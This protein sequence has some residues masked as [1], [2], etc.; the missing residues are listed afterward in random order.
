VSLVCLSDKQIAG[1]TLGLL[2]DELKGK[3]GFQKT[4]TDSLDYR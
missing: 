4:Q 3:F 1:A 2:S